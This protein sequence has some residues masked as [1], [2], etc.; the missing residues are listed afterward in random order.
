MR[1]VRILGAWLALFLLA[2]CPIEDDDDS[3]GDCG[4]DCPQVIQSVDVPDEIVAIPY[5]GD[6]W[7]N[8]WA[9][10]GKLYLSW[11]DGTGLGMCAPTA[12]GL[13]PGAWGPW[14]ATEHAP[15]SGCFWLAYP[16]EDVMQ[17]S[18]CEIF[19]C[20]A[21]CVPL[22]PFTDAGLMVL[23]GDVPSFDACGGANCIVQWNVPDPDTYPV[24]PDY[25]VV[26]DDKTSSMLFIG[27][28]LLIHAHTPSGGPTLGFLAVSADKGTSWQALRE[29]SPWGAGSSF[30]VGMLIHMGQAYGSNTDGYAYLLGV[31][32]ELADG[33]QSVKLARAPL[34]SVL[35]YGAWE[36][37]AGLDGDD[38]PTWSSSEA[39]ASAL[40]GLKTQVQGS[41]MYHEGTDRY[42]F[43]TG[44]EDFSA[45]GG[46][47]YE[48]A[49]PWGPW[50]RVGDLPE[51]NISSLVTKGYTDDVIYYTA[52]GGDRPYHL[53][54]RAIQLTTDP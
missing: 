9:D 45:G 24:G 31:P 3:D 27:E 52:A 25:T 37:F 46:A 16:A 54:I 38:Q 41:A 32:A 12:D 44:G 17:N 21:Q 15:D 14:A 18:F 7:S 10:D 8:A 34:E 22:C 19:D 6:L 1:T 23:D 50:V 40:G 26:K 36:Y 30:R 49:H 47:L 51:I 11:G 29:D 39:D 28:V 35:E 4:Q 48:A 13:T 5:Y 42:L 20:A 53:N 2:G 43:L 33:P